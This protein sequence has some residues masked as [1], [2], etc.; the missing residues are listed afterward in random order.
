MHIPQ[1]HGLP[2]SDVKRPQASRRFL[3][4]L[5]MLVAT[6]VVL[7]ACGGG[8]VPNM[9]SQVE[10]T[11]VAGGLRVD[12][13][14]GSSG[15]TGFKIYRETVAT[16]DLKPGEFEPQALAEIA[17][18]PGEARRYY[19]FT[20][21]EGSSYVYGVSA[22][23]P[24]GE[25]AVAQQVVPEP[26]SPL[27]GIEISIG[28]SGT[29]TV[30]ASGGGEVVECS[31]T[32]VA[33]FAQ[34][35]TVTLT[36]TGSGGQEFATWL[37]DCSGAGACQLELNDPTS[38]TASF[39][40]NVLRLVLDGDS[41]VSVAVS[42]GHGGQGANVCELQPGQSCGFGYPASV[43]V[44]INVTLAETGGQFT[45][46]GPVCTA[47]QNRYCLV[48]SPGGLTE[49]S[50]G[51]IR[52]PVAN[53]DSYGS[54]EDHPITVDAAAGVLANDV[55]SPWDTL[56]AVLVSDV[57][58]G[59]L[60]LAEDGGF[61]YSPKGDFNGA[62][63]FTYRTVDAYGNESE[64]VNVALAITA[65][66]DAPTFNIAANPPTYKDGPHP[67]VTINNFATAISPG[68]GPDEAGQA[69][70]FTVVREGAA[71]PNF[72][73]QPTISPTGT[74]TYHHQF[75]T[76]GTARFRVVLHDDGGVANGGQNA[77]EPRFIE[78]TATPLFLTVNVGGSGTGNVT[79]TAGVHDRGYGSM[80]TVTAAA[81]PTSRLT[82]WGGACAGVPATSG[83]CTFQITTDS[84]VSVTFT[85]VHRLDVSLAGSGIATV[86][87]GAPHDPN[88]QGPPWT[89]PRS[90]GGVDVLDGQTVTLTA[91]GYVT[92]VFQSWGGDCAGILTSTCQVVMNGNK[93]VVANFTD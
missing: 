38:V 26:V 85:A 92:T 37:E 54:L 84:T 32:C 12:W 25:S 69:L 1:G 13:V 62:D 34:G 76:F 83:S 7:V 27:P 82:A 17:T 43:G 86:S 67:A 75:G 93:S 68:G 47:P 73:A 48:N 36:A 59:Q 3:A 14:S 28:F 71:G 50:I 65:V 4:L 40:S 23:G 42:P 41:P 16:A 9:P 79:P 29:G 18:T 70:N 24:G 89:V 56:R 57:A 72:L 44:S 5:F 64:T 39:S 22:V 2:E 46:F 58:N 30:R 10:V 77:S 88:C 80:V 81:G 74:L 35:T 61:T 20:A 33:A 21:E 87:A 6:A 53:A 31:A 19:D 55:D 11:P 51:A 60:E 78:I 66:N 91:I 90:C 15:V 52:V 63:A 49:L 45:G 8:A